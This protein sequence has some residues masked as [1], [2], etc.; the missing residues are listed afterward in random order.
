MA[1]LGVK[2]PLSLDSSDGFTMI[3]DMKT[4]VK[5]NLKMLIL[6]NPGERVME[7]LFGVGM[8]RYLFENFS[9]NT[10]TTIDA[11]IREQ[12]SIYMPMVS[13]VDILFDSDAET[14]NT[15]KMRLRYSIPVINVKDLLEFTI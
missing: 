1:S 7:P 5:Q 4:L 12:I 14:Q 10:Y 8:N 2:L 9:Q 6:T 13:V 15:L 3:K 11:K